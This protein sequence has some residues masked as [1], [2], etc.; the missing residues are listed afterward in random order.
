MKDLDERRTADAIAVVG[1]GLMG[2][3]L[4]LALAESRT[5]R[6]VRVLGADVNPQAVMRAKAMGAI[7]DVWHEG[8]AG[9]DAPTLVILAMP[10]R[11]IAQWLKRQGRNLPAHCLVMDLGSTKQE[12]VAA[13]N[14]LG[15]KA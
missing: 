6:R 9:E 10:V 12:I 3:S 14:E 7:A 8:E 11:A 15:W 13:M 2:G 5:G 1:L 4:A